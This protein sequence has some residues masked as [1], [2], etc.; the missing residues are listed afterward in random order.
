MI[1]W[2]ILE[3]I[4]FLLLLVSRCER[5]SFPRSCVCGARADKRGGGVRLACVPRFLFHLTNTPS[6]GTDG[7]SP[8]CEP[9]APGPLMTDYAPW[10]LVT[11]VKWLGIHALLRGERSLRPCVYRA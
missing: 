2:A 8:V 4:S 1:T 9:R 3:S 5:V 7:V 6:D 11:L 10:H